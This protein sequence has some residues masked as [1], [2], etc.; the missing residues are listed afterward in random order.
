MHIPEKEPK[1]LPHIT[2]KYL[3]ESDQR[4]KQ[5]SKKTSKLLRRKCREKNICNFG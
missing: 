2:D 1:P 3:L 5:N 4:P